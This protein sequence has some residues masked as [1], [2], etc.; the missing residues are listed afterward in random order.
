MILHKISLC[1]DNNARIPRDPPTHRILVILLSLFP[2]VGDLMISPNLRRGEVPD[3][4]LWGNN[5]DEI[6]HASLR[7]L[8]GS[9]KFLDLTNRDYRGFYHDRVLRFLA[10]SPL[11]SQT[12]S[13]DVIGRPWGE[14]LTRAPRL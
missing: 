5:D 9:F 11:Q 4:G 6:Q 1:V 10:A 7:R 12:V 13:L 14:V 2:N 8:R 3:L